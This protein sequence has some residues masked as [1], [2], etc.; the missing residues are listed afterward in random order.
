M[1]TNGTHDVLSQA[2]IVFALR[3]PTA[4]T[5]T[6]TKGRENENIH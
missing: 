2:V 3:V 1:E 4:L 5:Q 6:S